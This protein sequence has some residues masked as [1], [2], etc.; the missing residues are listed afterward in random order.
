MQCF[1][2][3]SFAL[4]GRLSKSEMQRKAKESKRRQPSQ[5]MFQDLET[6]AGKKRGAHAI[7]D[8]MRSVDEHLNNCPAC[9][10]CSVILRLLPTLL[11]SIPLPPR[12]A[13]SHS[14]PPP[15]CLRPPS[16][17]SRSHDSSSWASLSLLRAPSS[18]VLSHPSSLSQRRHSIMC[19]FI[20]LCNYLY[21]LY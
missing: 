13:Y 12:S 14:H 21:S 9:S 20:S 17:P 18:P 2:F 10:L 16:P 8:T 15:A 5:R 11:Y 1:S 19:V 4:L 3:E 7:C 6:E